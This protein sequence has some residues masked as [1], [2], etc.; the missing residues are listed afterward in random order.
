[1]TRFM[2]SVPGYVYAQNKNDLYV[3]LFMS[4]DA[5]V[6]LAAGKVKLSQTTDYPWNGKIDL[7]INPE[8]ASKF[9]L[10]IRIPGWAQKQV[11]AGNLYSYVDT[12]TSPVLISVNG[13]PVVYNMT[14]GYAV[15]DRVWKK[16]DKVSFTLPMQVEKVVANAKV[17]EDIGKFSFQKGPIVYCLEGPDNKDSLVHNIMIDREAPVKV[18]FASNKLNGIDELTIDGTSARRQLNST[19]ILKTKQVVKAIPYY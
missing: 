10:N 12:K 19:E 15:L 2:P 8:K 18:S 13:K 14:K 11:V 5:E 17:K 9:A 3:N 1:M 7:Q 4:N 16:G 6:G